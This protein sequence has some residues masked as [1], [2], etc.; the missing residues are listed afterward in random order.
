MKRTP[1]VQSALQ[2]SIFATG[3]SAALDT[4]CSLVEGPPRK[5]FGRQTRRNNAHSSLRTTLALLRLAAS[6]VAFLTNAVLRPV[7]PALHEEQQP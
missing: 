2:P 7:D 1:L 5:D 4:L 6:S 3:S